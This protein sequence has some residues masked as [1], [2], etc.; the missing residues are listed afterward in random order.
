MITNID[1]CL[2]DV[3]RFPVPARTSRIQIYKPFSSLVE[4]E[5]NLAL[6]ERIVQV[7]CN[8]CMCKLCCSFVERCGW[9]SLLQH[10]SKHHHLPVVDITAR[11]TSLQALC[12]FVTLPWLFVALQPMLHH[13]SHVHIIVSRHCCYQYTINVCVYSTKIFTMIW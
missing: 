12:D 4:S 3:P 2:V 7:L 8:T 9:Q 10:T 5:Y 11:V 1:K 6:Y 13:R